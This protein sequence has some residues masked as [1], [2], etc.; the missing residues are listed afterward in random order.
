MQTQTIKTTEGVD[1]FD[2]SEKTQKLYEVIFS[3]GLNTAD[4]GDIEEKLIR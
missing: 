1:N 4:M 2:Y 3:Y